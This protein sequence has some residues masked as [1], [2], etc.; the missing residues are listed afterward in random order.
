MLLYLLIERFPLRVHR[1]VPAQ[2]ASDILRFTFREGQPQR[3]RNRLGNSSA[4][5]VALLAARQ[6]RQAGPA[7]AVLR[8]LLNFSVNVST[9]P[10]SKP[11]G[12][13]VS[14]MAA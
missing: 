5:Q 12:F 3:M 1:R 2:E 11:I 10:P 4:D 6:Q 8:V 13:S 9:E 14:K 7:D